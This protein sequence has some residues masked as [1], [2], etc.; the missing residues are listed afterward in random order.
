MK[1]VGIVLGLA[2]LAGC[3]GTGVK[4]PALTPQ[5]IAD[6]GACY[7]QVQTLAATAQSQVSACIALGQGL[8]SLK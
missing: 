8:K 3:T 4:L 2:A 1:V 7:A 6:A 5:N